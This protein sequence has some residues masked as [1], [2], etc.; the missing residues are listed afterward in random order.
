MR[1]VVVRVQTEPSGKNKD[2][3][4]Y[5]IRWE[6]SDRDEFARLANLAEM[7]EKCSITAA[8]GLLR[9]LPRSGPAEQTIAWL[10]RIANT[11]GRADTTSAEVSAQLQRFISIRRQQSKDA[12]RGI[13]AMTVHQAKNREFDGVVVMWPFEFKADDEGKRRLLYNAVTRA[14]RW[15]SV[16][17][18]S[19]KMLKSPPFS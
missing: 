1:E 12:D 7:P 16:I 15:C 9:T 5:A 14:R 19:D 2:L 8:V 4:P 3:G 13:H 10:Q 18:Q 17:V 11:T 6:E